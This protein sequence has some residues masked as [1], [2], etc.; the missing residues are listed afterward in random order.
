MEECNLSKQDCGGR[1]REK[2]ER[3][4]LQRERYAVEKQRGGREIPGHARVHK[5]RGL[6]RKLKKGGE[7]WNLRLQE[8]VLRKTRRWGGGERRRN[9]NSYSEEKKD[10]GGG[11]NEKK[12][13]ERSS[14]I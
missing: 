7:N 14:P 9:Q 3:S 12:A 2:K 8:Q 1:G 10:S 5:K 11:G 13:E 6:W 4:F